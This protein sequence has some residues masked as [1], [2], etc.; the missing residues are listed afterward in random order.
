MPPDGGRSGGKKAVLRGPIRREHPV[1]ATYAVKIAIFHPLGVL[2]GMPSLGPFPEHAKDDHVGPLVGCEISFFGATQFHFWEP[3]D[4]IV[5][6][7][8]GAS[9]TNFSHSSMG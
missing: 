6:I 4:F 2:V 8:F 3:P 5:G 9:A 7:H 1:S